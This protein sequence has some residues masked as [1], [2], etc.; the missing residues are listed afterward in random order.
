[1][2]IEK[3]RN[4]ILDENAYLVYLQEGGDAVLIDPGSEPD[5]F[6]SLLKQKNLN[7]T[8]ILLTHGH[9]DH[10]GAAAQ[11][12]EETGALIAIHEKDKKCLNSNVSSLAMFKLK[13]IIPSEPDIILSDGLELGIL[14]KKFL[15]IHTPGHTPGSCCFLTDDTMFSGD[16][17][18]LETVGRTDFPG[19]SSKQMEQSLARISEYDCTVYPGHGSKT[20]MEHER[21]HNFFLRRA[22]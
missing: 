15:V 4:G 21:A 14:G 11:I 1:M 12:K 2:N 10:I 6:L 5:I 17:L 18:F 13:K 16:T 20:T 7:L 3:V 9:F 22:T 19:S 8:H